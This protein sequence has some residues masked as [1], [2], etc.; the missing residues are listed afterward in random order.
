[1]GTDFE[2]VMDDF[3]SSD[4]NLKTVASYLLKA[5]AYFYKMQDAIF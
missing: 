4:G 2:K 5:R 3:L 1:V